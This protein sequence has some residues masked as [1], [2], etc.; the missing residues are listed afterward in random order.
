M[1]DD[2]SVERDTEVFVPPLPAKDETPRVRLS[3]RHAPRAIARHQSTGW[4]QS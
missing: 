4:T 1:P 2:A 3:L